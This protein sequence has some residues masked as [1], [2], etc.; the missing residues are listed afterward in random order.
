M[1]VFRLGCIYDRD[2]CGPDRLGQGRPGVHHGGQVGV[3]SRI[4]VSASPMTLARS[5][6]YSAQ[7][8]DWVGP[9]RILSGLRIGR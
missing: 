1:F 7:G 6:C 5:A 2:D 4:G 8:T 3:G 9:G